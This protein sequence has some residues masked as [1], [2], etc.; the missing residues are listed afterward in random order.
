[1][2]SRPMALVLILT[3]AAAGAATAQAPAAEADPISRLLFPPELVL[4]HGQ[5]IGLDETQRKTLRSEVQSAQHRFLDLQLDLQEASEALALL[6]KKTPVAEEEVLAQIDRVLAI[7][8]QIKRTHISLLVRIKN[9]LAPE[10]QA[11]LSALRA[12]VRP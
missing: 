4:G 7:E 5:E 1:M 12:E 10:Q 9:L 3:L 6:L 2:R 11:K 8:K